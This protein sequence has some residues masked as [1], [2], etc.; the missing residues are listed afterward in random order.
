MPECLFWKAERYLQER[1]NGKIETGQG[2][3]SALGPG[4]SGSRLTSSGERQKLEFEIITN[5]ALMPMVWAFN[6]FVSS[7]KIQIIRFEKKN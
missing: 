7:L 2:I 5:T 6:L 1:G 4:D 3:Q